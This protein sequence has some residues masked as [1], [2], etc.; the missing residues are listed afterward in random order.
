MTLKH[1]CL[2]GIYSGAFP[3]G[4]CSS[5]GCEKIDF[6][7]L[8]EFGTEKS[9][10]R[11]PKE[12]PLQCRHTFGFKTEIAKTPP[13]QFFHILLSRIPP[14]Y[15]QVSWADGTQMRVDRPFLRPVI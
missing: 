11:M 1:A 15:R 7:L 4:S 2:L 9:C 10:S 8:R 14:A 12:R 13:N 3:L 5:G 6:Q